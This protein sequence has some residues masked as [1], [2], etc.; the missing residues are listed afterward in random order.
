VQNKFSNKAIADIKDKQLAGSQA[1]KGK[2]KTAKD[3]KKCYEDAQ[4]KVKGP[5]WPGGAIPCR[6]IKAAMVRACKL[7]GFAMTDSKICFWVESDGEDEDGTGL[8]RI[9]KGKPQYFE[10]DVRVQG[11]TDIRPRPK[12]DTGWEARIRITY[13]A[14]MFSLEDVSNLLMRAGMQVGIGEGRN[15]SRSCVGC[16]WGS[17]RVAEKK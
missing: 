10:D 16:G 17:F 13:D 2:K 15:S 9:A 7:V 3:F 12:W 1:V 8:I 6:Q 11:G 14:D 4:Y 5:K